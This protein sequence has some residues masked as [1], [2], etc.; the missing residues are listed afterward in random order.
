M[1]SREIILANIEHSGAPR[2][3][4]TFDG[5]RLD[6]FEFVGGIRAEGYT[7]KRW[8]EGDFEY[9][10]DVWGNLW[11]RIGRFSYV[12]GLRWVPYM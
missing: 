3:G 10:D 12:R 11:R 8:E 4:L 5:G 2:C 6:D 9:Y 7:Q 1:N